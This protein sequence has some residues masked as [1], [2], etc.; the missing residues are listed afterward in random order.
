M[1]E[2]RRHALADHAPQS[3]R[4]PRQVTIAIVATFVAATLQLFVPRLLGQAVDQ[5]QGLG[6]GGAAATQAL[7][8]TAMLLL[9]ISI[10]RG[11]FT[12]TAELFQRGGRVSRRV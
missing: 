11:I 8:A 2:G 1:G 5:A 4:I 12:L 3:A 10:A 6:T 7:W 9:G